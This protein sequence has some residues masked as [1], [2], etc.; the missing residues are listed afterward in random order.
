MTLY[1]CNTILL[2]SKSKTCSFFVFTLWLLREDRINLELG[3]LLKFKGRPEVVRKSGQTEREVLRKPSS[4]RIR[5]GGGCPQ[6]QSL[7]EGPK[8]G[9]LS[10]C[11]W[12]VPA[13]WAGNYHYLPN[14]CDFQLLVTPN[15]TTISM[16]LCQVY[17][18]WIM[19]HKSNRNETTTRNGLEDVF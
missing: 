15:C 14:D 4:K 10:S 11:Q 5:R 1:I 16:P 8:W 12:E 3:V 9:N 18:L 13:A 2:L 6:G 17:F 19:F 7:Q